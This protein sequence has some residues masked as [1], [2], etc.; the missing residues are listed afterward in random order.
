V[1]SHLALNYASIGRHEQSG[2]YYALAVKTVDPGNRYGRMM[3]LHNYS[4]ELRSAGR[5]DE[6]LEMLQRGLDLALQI[7]RREMIPHFRVSLAEVAV[8]RRQWEEAAKYAE[9]AIEAARGYSEPLLSV[10]A[11]DALGVALYNEGHF[12]GSEAA[13]EAAIESNAALRAE[14]PAAPETLAL[15]MR[16]KISVYWHLMTTLLA[17]GRTA[18]ALA[19]AERAKAR[20]LVELLAGGKA[21]LG[22]TLTPEEKQKEQALRKKVSG[23][24][25]QIIDESRKSPP[26]QTRLGA[27][28]AQLE[29]ARLEVR[30]LENT[31]Y[32]AH[33]E[34]KL[35]RADIRA[36]VPAELMSRLP[37]RE[38]A[39]AEFATT[40]D[41]MVLFV[42]AREGVRSYTLKLEISRLA[43]DVA[44]FRDELAARDV[45]YHDLSRSLYATLLGPATAQIAGK[46]TIVI[47]PDGPLW[48]LPFQALETPAGKFL[49]EERAV[50]YAPSL[51]VLHETLALK[52]PTGAARALVITGPASADGKQ[53][54]SGLRQIYGAARTTVY[55]GSEATA[56]RL[57]NEAAGYQVLHLATH[58]VF[59]DRSPMLSYLVLAEHR[60]LDASEMMELP[61]RANL[62]VLS[63]CET[64]RGEAVNGEGLLGMSW[65]LLVA[66]SPATVASQ[67]QV[68][69]R[70]TTKLML[71]FHR[72]LKDGAA[73]G[74]A[75]RNATLS[76][77]HAGDYRHPFYWAAFALVG[78][79]F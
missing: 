57:R 2:Q 3:M 9:A 53:E 23:L 63:A 65:A 66:G 29:S 37:D 5:F 55:S 6:A 77:M 10:R 1:Y 20:V 40:E 76:L 38:T 78:N 48:K 25:Q 26:D 12:H 21:D 24:R 4:S 32:A 61:L 39:L 42:I 35:Q 14:L 45:N 16:D 15:F 75:L 71:A 31:L 74:E 47:V 44:Q 54:T 52:R 73:K 51:T 8:L 30:T 27:L 68:D 60:T 50:F 7:E 79:G 41:G 69:S 67:W 17:A 43:K 46:Q 13:L 34:L 56:A 49:I 70:S 33:E 64:G 36:V 22:K 28:N 59:Q 58:G 72:G 19:C 18:D 62:V 11:Y